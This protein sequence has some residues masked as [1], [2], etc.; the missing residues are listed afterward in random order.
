MINAIVSLIIVL[1]MLG[2]LTGVLFYLK[3]DINK[4]NKRMDVDQEGDTAADTRINL[5]TADIENNYATRRQL[6]A[7]AADM[8]VRLTTSQTALQTQLTDMNKATQSRITDF[9]N[10]METQVNGLATELRTFDSQLDFRQRVLQEEVVAMHADFDTKHFTLDGEWD[11]TKAEASGDLL[12][13]NIIPG[14]K[15]AVVVG[16]SMNVVGKLGFSDLANGYTLGVSG[17]DLSLKLPA[18]TGK[19]QL[20]NGGTNSPQHTFDLNG[21]V[22]HVGDVLASGVSR[23]AGE[24][25]WLH[26]N[27]R[28]D[29]S[30]GTMV[31]G[32]VVADG[33]V[34]VGEWV[35]V[36]NGM[37]YVKDKLG[38]GTK[39]PAEALDV[40]GN[41]RV[42][43]L[44]IGSYVLFEE[45]G[46][47][48]IGKDSKTSKIL[49]ISGTD[50]YRLSTFNNVDGTAPGWGVNNLGQTVGF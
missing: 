22:T 21:N 28:G 9:K 13:N 27:Q 32:S 50:V 14:S 33:G 4:I 48:Y 38:V 12:I 44:W 19:F 37:L 3:N 6:K 5:L 42:N 20:V 49:K 25:D 39:N 34:S 45:N 16:T 41:A 2:A 46:H 23:A 1:A 8:D 17:D 11:L 29:V 15:A 40:K 24:K 30:E 47:L 43:D 10:A 26:L 31:H 35:K 36:P 7:T 18:K